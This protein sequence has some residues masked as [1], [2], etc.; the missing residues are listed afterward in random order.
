MRNVRYSKTSIEHFNALLAVGAFQ[1][2]RGVA[3]EKQSRVYNAVDQHISLYPDKQKDT[4]LDLCVYA[5][6]KTP[7]VLLYEFDDT[8]VR[9]FYILHS[10]MSRKGLRKDT[11]T[12]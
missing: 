4:R 7:F 9:V 2:G 8:E 3:V 10:H 6:H 1:F 11:V 12:W 5:V